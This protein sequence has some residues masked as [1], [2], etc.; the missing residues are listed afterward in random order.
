MEQTDRGPGGA[1]SSGGHGGAGSS[2][3]HGGAG[4]SE[5]MAEQGA[6]KAMAEQEAR[7]AMVGPPPRP[8]PQPPPQSLRPEPY[9]PPQKISLGKLRGIRSPPGL[10][11]QKQLKRPWSL[12]GQI[13]PRPAGLSIRQRPAGD[14]IIGWLDK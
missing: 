3:G 6:R 14:T 7:E 8:R 4:S 10:N 1:G 12:T 2:G 11:A 13:R 9:Y 5:A